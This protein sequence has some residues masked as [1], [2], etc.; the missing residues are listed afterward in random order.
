KKGDTW[1]ES[2]VYEDPWTLRKVRRVTQVGLYNQTPT[3]HTNTAFTEDGEF[4][5]FASA[6]LG[7]SALFRC[8]VSTGDITQVTD[9]VDGVGTRDELHKQNATSTGNGM[10]I[11]MLMC[12]APK[13]RWVVYVVG[14]SFKAVHLETFEERTLIADIGVDWIAGQ[15]SVDPE[16]THAIVPVMSAHPDI[17]QGKHPTKAYMPHF[18]KVGP[19]VRLLQVPLT[20]GDVETVYAEDGIG[21]AH[22][23]HNPQDP[24]LILVDR[25]KP[26]LLWGGSDGKTNRIWALRLS[27]GKLTELPPQDKARFQVHCAWTFD[28]QGVLYH[29]RSA[30]AGHFIGV[31][32]PEGNPIREYLFRDAQAYGHVSAM[33]NRPAIILDGNI[34]DDLL[35]WVYYDQEKP[36]VE[37]IAKHGTN[38]GALPWQYSHPHPLSDPTGSW[39]SFNA[40]NRGRSD[41]FV[42]EV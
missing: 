35:V 33:A 2:T 12:I 5:I 40:A 31:V 8:H 22:C 16:E 21:C 26:P 9:L 6:R 14:R 17:A 42:V 1:N 19:K 37:V 38:W 18:E 15:P 10:G 27:T 24:D 36:R 3:Y 32:D 29:G 7:G 25:D 23:P 11:T 30:E 39:I 34:S 20:G 4:L 13:S 41:V 28:G